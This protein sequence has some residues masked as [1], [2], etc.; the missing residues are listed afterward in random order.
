MVSVCHMPT[1]PVRRALSAIASETNPQ[2]GKREVKCLRPLV[3]QA[4]EVLRERLEAEGSVVD[5]LRGRAR[6]ADSV[7]LGLSQIA[8]VAIGMRSDKKIAPLA[9]VAVGGYGRDE[10]APG[11]DL[12]LLFVL[13]DSS[14]LGVGATATA[15]YVHAVIAGLWDLG[16]VVDH[17][18]RS[19]RECFELAHDKPAVLAGLLDRRFLWGHSGLF[20][21]LDADIVRLFSGPDAGRWRRAMGLAMTSTP[22]RGAGK[23]TSID[24]PDVKRGPGGL[25][26]LQRVLLANMLA[27]GRPTA[28]AE[29]TL[30]EAHHF[31]SL[32]RCHLHFLVGHAE[33]R[34][35]STLQ[36]DV[37]RRLGFDGP[38]G[39]TALPLLQLFHRH[40]NNVLR[41]AALTTAWR[42]CAL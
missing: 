8:S 32:V 38:R 6:L 25:R 40:A 12:D 24:E 28:L 21:S 33:D 34:L 35:S 22:R 30:V 26:D 11:S 4:H 42:S 20:A 9:V 18:A 13:P 17:A 37:A 7:V 29:P 10:L 41:A 2:V 15:A 14:R 31:L 19:S 1:A 36:P 16:F 39:N 5:Y 23:K 3:V 27:S